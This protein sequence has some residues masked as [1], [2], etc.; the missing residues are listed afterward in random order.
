MVLVDNVFGIPRFYPLGLK[1]SSNSDNDKYYFICQPT[2]TNPT[3]LRYFLSFHKR[4]LNVFFRKLSSSISVW[5]K[6]DLYW[7]VSKDHLM[8]S[9]KIVPYNF[10]GHTCHLI[11]EVWSNLMLPFPNS[12]IFVDI[13][14][15]QHF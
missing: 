1:A 8:R 3:N 14:L 6:Q 10:G 11:Y 4:P 13:F 7:M 9:L 15:T 5:Q 12:D 2:Q